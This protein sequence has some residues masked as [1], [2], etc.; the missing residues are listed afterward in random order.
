MDVGGARW[1]DCERVEIG[2]GE[3]QVT[4]GLRSWAEGKEGTEGEDGKPGGGGGGG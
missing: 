1:K 4:R 2:G 3:G